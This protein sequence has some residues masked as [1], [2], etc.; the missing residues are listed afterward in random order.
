M[1]IDTFRMSLPWVYLMYDFASKTFKKQVS[2]DHWSFSCFSQ[3]VDI[4]QL[5]LPRL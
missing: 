3:P 2:V 4:S 5:I 1:I